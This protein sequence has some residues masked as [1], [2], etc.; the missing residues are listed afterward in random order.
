M[1]VLAFVRYMIPCYGTICKE[2]IKNYG[3]SRSFFT[4]NSGRS[5]MGVTGFGEMDPVPRCKYR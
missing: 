2:K 5:P 3:V 1:S 4:K